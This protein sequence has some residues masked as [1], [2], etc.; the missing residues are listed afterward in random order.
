MTLFV[1]ISVWSL[2]LR[3]DSPPGVTQVKAL[4]SALADG[5]SIATTGLVPQELLQGFSG[6]KQARE[7]IGR[8]G[9]IPLISPT[10]ADHMEAAAL[11]NHCRRS[12]VQIGTIDAIIAQLCIGNDLELLTTDGDFTGVARYAKLRVWFGG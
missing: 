8:F 2:L 6:P 5:S 1:D 4:Q 7:I 11:R 9:S 12:G 3:R 10:R